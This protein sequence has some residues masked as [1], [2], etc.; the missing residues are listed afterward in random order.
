VTVVD[1]QGEQVVVV[2]VGLANRRGPAALDTV[3]DRLR[4]E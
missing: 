1:V 2:V 4:A 3:V